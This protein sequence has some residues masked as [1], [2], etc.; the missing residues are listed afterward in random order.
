M[1]DILKKFSAVWLLFT[2]FAL[3]IIFI[4]SGIG[5]FVISRDY[6]RLNTETLRLRQEYITS[7]RQQIKEEVEHSVSFVQYNWANAEDRLR[8][9]LKDRTYEAF[10][11]AT[12]LYEVNKGRASDREI[13]N[14]IMEALR[15]IRFND[16]R[17]YFFV[18]G[19]NGL[20]ILF[21][22][23]P[24]LEGQS[25]LDTR[26]TRGAYV[27]RD[28]IELVRREGEGYYQY[29]WSKPSAQGTDFRKIA[30]VKYFAPFDCLIGTGEYLDDV[31]QDIQKEVLE[32]I[33]KIRFGKDGYIFVVSYEGVTLMNSLQPERIGKN[34]WD[35]TDPNGVKVVQEERRAAE[36][37]EGDFILYRWEKPSTNE[38]RPKLSFVKGFPQ[39][40]W[41][42]GAGVYTDDIEP[43]IT[44]MDAAT[45][46]ETRKDL[47]RLGL[48]LTVILL[49][50]LS[51]C[52]RLSHY[53]KREL[54]LFLH[55]F[56]EAATGG[57]PI[58]TEQIFLREFQLL[59]QSAN[60]MLEER[61]KAADD[62][63]ESEVRF[64][65]LFSNMAEGVALHE[66]ILDKSAKPADYRI[67]D[68][69]QQYERL[70]GLRR[71]QVVGKS[72]IEAYGTPEAPYL[73]EF[74]KVALSGI[75]SQFQTY[76]APLERHFEIS[77]APWGNNG[78]ATLFSDVTS[79]MQAKKE[80]KRLEDR[81]QRAEKMEALGTLAGGVAHDLNNVLGIV[82]GYSEL[83]LDDL[84]ESSSARAEA[85]E[86]LKAGQ[87]AAAIVQ[88]LLTLARRGVTGRQVLNL[89]NI[90]M[91]CQKSPE[92]T[93]VL[94]FH[95]NLEIKTDLEPD[96]LNLSGSS[97]HLG[98]SFMNLV[99][100]AA[101]AMPNG[102][103]FT[104][105]TANCY[106]DKPISGY[107]EVLEGDYVVLTVADTGEGIPASDLTR[108]FE[109]F[110]TKKVMGRSGTGLGLAVVWGTMKDHLG[111]INVESQEGKGTIFTLYFPVTREEISQ[112][113][114]SISV[115]EFIGNGESILVVDDVNQQRELAQRMLTK[116]NYMVTTVASGEEA[117]DYLEE[118]A[119]DLVVL[120]MIMEPGMDGLDTYRNILDI[121]P[122]QKA[123]IVSGFAETERVTKAQSL[124][125]GTYVKKPYVL[126]KLGLAVKEELDRSA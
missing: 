120:D 49:T 70:L 94:T 54:D 26:D 114:A 28:M 96:L 98:K 21:A 5:Y 16:G 14:L 117:V 52:F 79:R 90:I 103:T 62:F 118:H 6:Q 31:E 122:R 104:V 4:V 63:K 42:I 71:T 35:M 69:N 8:N 109:P 55:F 36:K 78:F 112:E 115:A 101:E 89:N 11:I 37:A 66:L 76:F 48:T 22:D 82:V 38:I 91:D 7:Q 59:G 2:G 92:F 97:V 67:I 50:G 121:H 87:R 81:L 51:I 43:V 34:I 30:F 116:L 93:K 105:K 126:E 24:E 125:A 68:I 102:G 83:L 60:R 39:W 86:I 99:S 75:P 40:Q 15:P 9:N 110:Y 18:T 58:A 46:K 33:S 84:D 12:N 100:N 65:S 61:Q 17:G 1:K 53:F 32:R 73:N 111:Y 123:I 80:Q 25:M 13:Q 56:K 64:Y 3:S 119:V 113:Q 124:G 106:L 85:T 29:T 27:I 41:M 20:E 72:A 23:R 95:P 10:A 107:D 57:K 44:A 88:D 77:V 47:Y 74:S 19:L 108:I 45:R